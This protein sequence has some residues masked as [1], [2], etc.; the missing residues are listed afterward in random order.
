MTE[1]TVVYV[2]VGTATNN[3]AI[4]GQ[5]GEF[6]T[7]TV[8]IGAAVALT[9]AVASNVTS[10]SLTAGDWDISAVLDHNIAATTSLT[11]L[12]ASISLTSGAL[13]PQAGGSGLGTDATGTA[14]FAAMIPTAGITQA[15]PLVRLSIAGTT[16]VFLVAQ[17]AFTV[18]TISA[19]GTLRARRVR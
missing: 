16:S 19:Y 10:I 5:I 13:S 14:S 17:D 8:A 9:T 4:A 2:P 11:Q 12:N 1:T 3:N 18:S 6:V 7:A 15:I